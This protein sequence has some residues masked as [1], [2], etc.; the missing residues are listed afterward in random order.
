MAWIAVCIRSPSAEDQREELGDGQDGVV[1][2]QI[3]SVGLDIW[4]GRGELYLMGSKMSSY[5]L[6]LV[7]YHSLNSF[8]SRL[9][10]LR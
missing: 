2:Q 7:S 4:I 3:G 8:G 9:P 1:E 6:R 5:L 10:F